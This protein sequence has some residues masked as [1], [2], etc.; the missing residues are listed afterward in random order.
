MAQ[1]EEADKT[2]SDVVTFLRAR[3]QDDWNHARDAMMGS[4]QWRAERTV[5]VLDTGAEIA[6]V[7][8]GPADHIARFDPARVL[9]EVAAKRAIVDAYEGRQEVAPLPTLQ[10]GLDTAVH[11]LASVYADHVDY[12]EEWRP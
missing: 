3:L 10:N 7:F 4:G 11:L 1:D 5:V 2:T 8:L 9:A 12:R 6:D